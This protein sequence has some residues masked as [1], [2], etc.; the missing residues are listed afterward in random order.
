MFSI[1][2]VSLLGKKLIYCSAAPEDNPYLVVEDDSCKQKR[3]NWVSY[4]LNYDSVLNGMLTLLVTSSL[5]NWD[6]LMYQ[7]ID[8]NQE[9]SGPIQGNSPGYAYFYIFFILLCSFFLL[10]LLIGVLFMTFKEVQEDINRKGH[11][12][13]DD[14]DNNKIV[15]EIEGI[16]IDENDDQYQTKNFSKEQ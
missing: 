9:M 1:L 3:G 14:Y 13:Q 10:N 16:K 6:T 11:S 5:N 7:A 8:A 12:S 2:G 4:P 15:L